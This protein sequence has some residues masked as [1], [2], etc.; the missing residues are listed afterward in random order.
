MSDN[1]S[2]LKSHETPIERVYKEP[3]RTDD[4]FTH[5]H[6]NKYSLVKFKNVKYNCKTLKAS[7]KQKTFI[8]K[9]NTVNGKGVK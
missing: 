2:E 1:F 9:K 3:N 4:R 5:I 7:R 6:R 8:Y